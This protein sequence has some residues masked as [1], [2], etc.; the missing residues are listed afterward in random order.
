M[1]GSIVFSVPLSVSGFLCPHSQCRPECSGG[2][3]SGMQWTFRRVTSA[4]T[5]QDELGA[6]RKETQWGKLGTL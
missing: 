5:V 2:K 4:V 6:T 3:Q 1:P